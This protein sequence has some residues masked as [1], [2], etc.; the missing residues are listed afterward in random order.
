MT[1]TIPVDSKMIWDTSLKT[2]IF[3]GTLGG[4]NM[5]FPSKNDPKFH[6]FAWGCKVGPYDLHGVMGRL[7]MAENKWVTGVITPIHSGIN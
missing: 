2:N 7:S 1:K 6:S 5:I 3:S 4:W